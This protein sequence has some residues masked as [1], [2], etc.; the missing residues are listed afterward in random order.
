MSVSEMRNEL[1]MLQKE[2]ADYQPV[3]KMKKSDISGLIERLKFK[4]ETTPLMA[5][6]KHKPVIVSESDEEIMGL[7][8]VKPVKTIKV[9]NNVK[10]V[11]EDKVKEVKVNVK[12][13]D[14]P[15]VKEDVKERMARIRAMKKKE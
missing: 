9:K 7:E 6:P 2:H 15:V 10:V 3:S 13:D 1:K 4:R 11:K 5:L 14:K 8:K 12:A